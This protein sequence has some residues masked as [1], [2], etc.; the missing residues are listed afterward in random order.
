[1][2]NP[3][4]HILLVDD[5]PSLT[6]LLSLRLEAEGFAVT[7]AQSGAQALKVLSVQDD[8]QLV[9]S[10]LCMG[11]MDGLE[12]FEQIQ[13]RDSG[14]PVIIITAQGSIPEAVSATQR[15]VFGF[16]TK[17]IDKNEL[18]AQINAALLHSGRIVKGNRKDQWRAH[19]LSRS[20][21]MEQLL[22]KAKR[23]ADSGVSILISG[24][25]GSGKEL[26]AQGI[27]RASSR[28]DQPF[29]AVN[30]GALPE[31]LLESELFGHVK[32]AFSGA[33]RDHLG[34]FR[35]ADGGT[36]LLDEIGDM[37]VAL[38]VKLLRVLQER[39]VRPVGST[40]NYGVDVR[41]IS[42]THKN[43]EQAML[44]G[45]FRED[46]F[47]RLNVVNLVI[48]DL[49]ERPEDI[50]LMANRFLS[51]TVKGR[52][53]EVT[54]FA[55]DALR[56]LIG[57]K[58]P[59]NVRQLENVVQQT[60]ALAH[61]KVIPVSLV[62]AALAKQVGFLSSY[63]EARHHFERDYLVKVLKLSDGNVSQAARLAQ[64]NR[65]DFYK[66]LQRHGLNADQFKN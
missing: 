56:L 16:L 38:Q 1:M 23:V 25:S 34:L 60:A 5:D 29:V 14:L 63:S 12:L 53:R 47:Y 43:L 21:V 46:L 42:A 33:T 6:R 41:I 50:P 30:C 2:N 51:E 61:T 55:P 9:I 26:L 10:D 4:S 57:A 62:S 59:G 28:C 54:S 7:S 32:G 48:P 13:A 40:Q 58:W 3:S 22:A 36:L 17:P 65:T 27:H 11:G 37:S 35:A 31:P 15:G 8:I 19:I 49:N 52:R 66:L 18:I 45:Q 64:R 20:E 44:C 24:S 39:Q